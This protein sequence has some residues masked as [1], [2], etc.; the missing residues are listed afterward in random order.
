[1]RG[2]AVRNTGLRRGYRLS[3]PPACDGPKRAGHARRL[4]KGENPGVLPLYE[5]LSLDAAYLP[6]LL[7]KNWRRRLNS[8]DNTLLHVRCVHSVLD[9]NPPAMPRDGV[10]RA[11]VLGPG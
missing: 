3:V 4:Q 5:V 9:R 1:M 2:R 8:V 6:I 11:V 10:P 7:S